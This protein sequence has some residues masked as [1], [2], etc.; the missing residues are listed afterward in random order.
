MPKDYPYIIN[1]DSGSI[2]ASSD[3]T[4]EISMGA[5]EEFIAHKAV[6]LSATGAFDLEIK[7]QSGLAYQ[8]EKVRFTTDFNGNRLFELPMPLQMENSS[9][10]KF[11]FTDVSAAANRVRM[12]LY[13]VRRVT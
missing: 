1:I 12:Q 3:A 5:N 6:L 9:V 8:Q 11:K 13:G 4:D 7:D 10:F 2:T